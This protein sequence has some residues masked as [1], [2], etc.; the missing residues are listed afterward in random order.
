MK[1]NNK[2]VKFTAILATALMAVSATGISTSA[3]GVKKMEAAKSTVAA[4][5][6]SFKKYSKANATE[7]LIALSGK[8][9]KPGQEIEIPLTTYTGNTCTCYDV[10]IEYDSRLEFETLES[11]KSASTTFCAFEQDGMS[12]VSIN[13]YNN[14]YSRTDGS[15]IPFTDGEAVAT[16]KFKV[17][18]NAENDNYF[19]SFNEIPSFSTD[20]ADYDD[21]AAKDAMV[22]VTGGADK[23]V[24][25]NC[26]QLKNVF[27]I[28]GQNA[29]V[30]V[31]PFSNNECSCYDMLIEYDPALLLEEGGVTGANSFTIFEED[32]RCFVSLIGYT[33]DHYKDGTPMASLNFILPEDANPGDSFSV[34]VAQ[35]SSFATTTAEL[36]DKKF[37]NAA[38]TI[39]AGYT[40]SGLTEYKTYQILSDKGEVIGTKVGRRGDFNGDGVTNIRDAAAIA[41]YI[42]SGKKGIAT[43]EALFFAII[44]DNCK[45]LSIRDAAAIASFA[46]R[47]CKWK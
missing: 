44:N 20:E 21:Y 35:L 32:G 27:G 2:M 10:V 17:P 24:E 22:T 19:I 42:A 18:E 30:Q 28:A 23:V 5:K 33:T 41:K 14:A 9:A 4:V 13:A 31:V 29:V 25:G 37:Y 16:L 15:R 7:N 1:K 11:L 39:A 40:P 36:P 26:V 3:Q 43:L 8:V 34:E 45:N 46:A 38:I 6:K 47:G 12:Y